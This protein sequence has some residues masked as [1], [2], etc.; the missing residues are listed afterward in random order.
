MCRFSRGRLA[1]FY[2]YLPH[3]GILLCR[4]PPESMETACFREEGWLDRMQTESALRTLRRVFFWATEWIRGGRPLEPS[5]PFRGPFGSFRGIGG[6]VT[7]RCPFWSF[8]SKNR[9]RFLVYQI[10]GL[11]STRET[12]LFALK[13]HLVEGDPKVPS[14]LKRKQNRLGDGDSELSLV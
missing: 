3:S 13:G 4:K 7:Y 1:P 8:W 12:H 5:L 6:R 2:C 11:S 9:W 10:G 14:P